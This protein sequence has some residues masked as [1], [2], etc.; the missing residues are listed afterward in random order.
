M[1]WHPIS[2]SNPINISCQKKLDVNVI[3]ATNEKDL[4]RCPRSILSVNGVF[5][6]L[7]GGWCNFFHVD[8]GVSFLKNN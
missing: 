2:E 4:H 7:F 5:Q 8:P 1:K 6:N 3:R